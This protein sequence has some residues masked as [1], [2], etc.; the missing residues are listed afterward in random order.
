MDQGWIQVT[1]GS[2][3]R[4]WQE[5]LSDLPTPGGSFQCGNCDV[6][7]P[8]SDFVKTSEGYDILK[9]FHGHPT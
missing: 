6:A 7:A 3:D 2:C 4:E 8:I 9:Q 5:R 1:C